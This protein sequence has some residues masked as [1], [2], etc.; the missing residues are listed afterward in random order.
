MKISTSNR[1]RSERTRIYRAAKCM[2]AIHTIHPPSLHLLDVVR[3]N[4]LSDTTP[5]NISPAITAVLVDENKSISFS[6]VPFHI[7][8]GFIFVQCLDILQFLGSSS[9][10]NGWT[11]ALLC[12]AAGQ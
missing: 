9:W 1:S 8:A 12:C 3:R 10:C 5:F 4:T 6:H 7:A 11:D 2:L